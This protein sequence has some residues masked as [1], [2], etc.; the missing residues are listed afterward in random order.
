MGK[1]PKS[2]YIRCAK[3]QKKDKSGLLT[4]NI[5][6]FLATCNNREKECV[7]EAYNILNEYADQIYGK[8]VLEN[9]TTTLPGIPIRKNNIWRATRP[10]E[11]T[12]MVFNTGLTHLGSEA[13]IL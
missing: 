11:L 8:E 12:P 3:I 13:S 1:R 6:G 10:S 7:Q 4:Q 5:S 9:S 2:Y